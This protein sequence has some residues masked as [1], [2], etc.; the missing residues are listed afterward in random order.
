MPE[1]VAC[2]AR[3]QVDDSVNFMG[4]LFQAVL[5]ITD[6]KKTI[7]SSPCSGWFDAT[8]K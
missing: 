6:P 4:R 1:G 5:V 3:V 2:L 8:G 7:F